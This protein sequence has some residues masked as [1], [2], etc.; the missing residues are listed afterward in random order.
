M[1]I[2][3]LVVLFLCGC[4]GVI[5]SNDDVGDD[6]GADGG[7]PVDDGGNPLIDADETLLVDADQSCDFGYLRV[8]VNNDGD[9][10]HPGPDSVLTNAMAILSSTLTAVPVPQADEDRV[11]AYLRDKLAFVSPNVQVITDRPEENEANYVMIVLTNVD[12]PQV[13]P[14]WPLAGCYGSTGTLGNSHVGIGIVDQSAWP[15]ER[16]ALQAVGILAG[17]GR[18]DASCMSVSASTD[19][20]LVDG[21][22]TLSGGMCGPFPIQDEMATFDNWFACGAWQ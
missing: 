22:S 2:S 18:T 14:D 8:Y 16:K 9:T 3:I 13:S 1:R 15:L 6:D 5:G 4:G 20:E 12:A 19:C 11:V 21:M 17:L 7:V 10:I